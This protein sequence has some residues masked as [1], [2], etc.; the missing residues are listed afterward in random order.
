MQVRRRKEGRK[1]AREGG[2]DRGVRRGEPA[3]PFQITT[4]VERGG[5]EGDKRRACARWGKQETFIL[6]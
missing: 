5:M 6:S 1:E 2:R 3:I 4:E